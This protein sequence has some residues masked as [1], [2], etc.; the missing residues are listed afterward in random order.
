MA[1]LTDITLFDFDATPSTI[2][3]RALPVADIASTVIFLYEG[4]GTPSTIILRD[5]T[6]LSGGAVFPTQFA[7][8]RVFYGGVVRSLCMVATA[9]APAGMGGQI[10]IDKNGT[11]LA[12]YLVETTD[13]NASSVR[14]NTSAGVKAV[15]LLT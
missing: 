3:L 7:G 9:D 15:R 13:P 12:V 10:R 11:T 8:L 1:S 6:T 14:I 5:P 2:I 4:D